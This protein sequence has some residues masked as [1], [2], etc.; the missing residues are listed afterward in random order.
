MTASSTLSDSDANEYSSTSEESATETEIEF[1]F[2]VDSLP[3]TSDS[4]NDHLKYI[5][6][7]QD[8]SKE[9]CTIVFETLTKNS[10][11]NESQ[12]ELLELLG[13]EKI[14]LIEFL[15]SNRDAVVRAY[16]LY[17]ND[18]HRKKNASKTHSQAEKQRQQQSDTA[19]PIVASEILVHTETERKIKKQIRKEEKRLNKLNLQS[20]Q[21]EFGETFDPSQLRKLR[22]EQ[23]TEARILQLYNQKRLDTMQQPISKNV[24][25]PYVFDSMLQVKQTSAFVAGSKI[26]L[27]ENISRND[28]RIMEEIFIPASGENTHFFC[29]Y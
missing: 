11:S 26:L 20:L 10:S 16:S 25:F 9:M 12:N 6:W 15:F 7:T 5:E 21:N 19:K 2:P 17:M 4:L 23:L 8:M 3:K 29:C 28:D 14:E 18:I 24:L 22:E 1:K 13:F 27:P